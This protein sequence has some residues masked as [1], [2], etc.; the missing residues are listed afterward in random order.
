MRSECS[1]SKRPADGGDEDHPE[2]H[3]GSVPMM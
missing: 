3:R 2:I 1:N